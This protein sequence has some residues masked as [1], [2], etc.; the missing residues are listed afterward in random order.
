MSSAAALEFAQALLQF[1]ALLCGL[2]LSVHL[3]VKRVARSTVLAR[4][5]KLVEAI[6][7]VT[8][9]LGEVLEEMRQ[10]RS[11]LTHTAREHGRLKRRVSRLAAEVQRLRDTAPPAHPPHIPGA[12]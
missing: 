9:E 5:D 8:Q 4:V 6:D 3:Y 1:V 7:G 10:M 12:H 2:V 11:E